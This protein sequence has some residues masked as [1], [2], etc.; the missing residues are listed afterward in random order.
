MNGGMRIFGYWLGVAL[1][2]AGAAAALAERLGGPP[3]ISL[4]WTWAQ[5]NSN[6]LVGFQSLIENHVARW[7]WPPIQE[8]LVAPTWLI[9]VPLGL[10]LVFACN[11]GP[12]RLRA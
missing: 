10:L 4:G 11:A 8:L 5:I 6:S 2:I 12:W 9:L 1:L 7:L 3:R